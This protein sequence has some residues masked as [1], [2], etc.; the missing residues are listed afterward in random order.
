MGS[1][2]WGGAPAGGVETQVRTLVRSGPGFLG[3]QV[4]LSNAL[5]RLSG[6]KA[7]FSFCLKLNISICPLSQKLAHVSRG[8]SPAGAGLGAKRRGGWRPMHK[9]GWVVLEGRDFR[10]A[11]VHLMRGFGEALP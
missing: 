8:R 10:G 7:A 6:Y 5:S 2:Q 9:G 4:L 3:P 1:R 11:S